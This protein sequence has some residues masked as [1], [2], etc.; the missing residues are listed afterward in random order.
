MFEIIKS[1]IRN[2]DFELKD[3]LYKINKMWIESA[4]TEEQKT[5]LD[6]LARQNAVA[7]NS[8]APIQEQINNANSRIDKLEARIEALEN[9]ETGEVTEPEQPVETDEYPAFVQPTE[10]HDC[11]NTGMKMTFNGE[12]YICKIDGCVWDPV[13]YPD[14]WEKVVEEN[15]DEVEQTVTN[16]EG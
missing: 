10:A 6:S 11:Y 8:Y 15:T 14:A 7:E 16:E 9:K 12:K 4:I 2:K 1:V 13:T 5:E 3:M